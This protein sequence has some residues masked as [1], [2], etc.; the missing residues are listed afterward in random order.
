MDWIVQAIVTGITAFVATNIDDIVIMVIFFAQSDATFH[1]KH[2]VVGKYLGFTVLVLASFPGFFGSLMLPRPWIGLLGFLPIVIGIYHLVQSREDEQVQT[3]SLTP[4][5]MLKPEGDRS[6]L[7]QFAR[8]FNP[9][10]YAVAAVTVANGGDNI[11]IYVPLF[12]NSTLHSLLVMLGV[13]YGLVGL[14]CYLAY[15]LTRQPTIARLLAQHGQRIV[16][17]VLIGL[18]VFILVESESYQLLPLF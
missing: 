2:V 16:P 8:L 6:F 7:S 17:F 18:G 11:G 3:V 1:P 12:A 13:F 9:Q 10:I 5:S 15:R 4:S 14:W